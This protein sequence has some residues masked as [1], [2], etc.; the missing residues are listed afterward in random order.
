MSIKT[1][2]SEEKEKILWLFTFNYLKPFKKYY[3]DREELSTDLSKIIHESKPLYKKILKRKAISEEKKN[4][5]NIDN[6]KY[7]PTETH[8]RAYENWEDFS[9]EDLETSIKVLDLTNLEKERREAIFKDKIKEK[10]KCNIF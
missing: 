8:K 9:E 6:E 4:L 7:I 3:T 1:K 10:L 5:K 2:V